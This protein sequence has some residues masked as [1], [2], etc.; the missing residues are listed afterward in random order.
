[1]RPSGGTHH[2]LTQARAGLQVHLPHA[3]SYAVA[4]LVDDYCPAGYPRPTGADAGHLRG[5]VP[6]GMAVVLNCPAAFR[7]TASACPEKHLQAAEAL[8]ADVIGVSLD[9]AGNVLA[10]R[11]LAL[12]RATGIPNGLAGVGYH[13]PNIPDLVAGT[14][15]APELSET[16]FAGG[17]CYCFR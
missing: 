11:M 12:M 17:P 6:H 3:M 16:S 1:M 9:D 4:G 8:G 14:S 2:S 10:E 7:Y 5:L 15:A 13:E